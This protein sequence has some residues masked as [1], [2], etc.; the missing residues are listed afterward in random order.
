MNA[1][2][3]LRGGGKLLDMLAKMWQIEQILLGEHCGG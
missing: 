3:L 2:E 1:G